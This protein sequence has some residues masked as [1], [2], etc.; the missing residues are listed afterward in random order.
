MLE[1]CAFDFREPSRPL[2]NHPIVILEWDGDRLRSTWPELELRAWFLTW[3]AALASVLHP[4]ND[5]V[6]LLIRT[7]VA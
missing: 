1:Q 3:D 7:G 2:P 6:R 5:K 4:L